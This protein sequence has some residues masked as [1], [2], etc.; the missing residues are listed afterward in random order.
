MAFGDAKGA[1]VQLLKRV[2]GPQYEQADAGLPLTG[3]KDW[4]SV[5]YLQLVLE[6]ENF[7]GQQLAAEDIERLVSIGDIEAI[8]ARK[9]TA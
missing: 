1:S 6:I 2:L 5:K 4:D 7:L 8:L 3:L 9:S